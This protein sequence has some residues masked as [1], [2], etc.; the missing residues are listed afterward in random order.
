MGEIEGANKEQ[1]VILKEHQKQHKKY[2]SDLDS[3]HETLRQIENYNEEVMSE[4]AITRRAAYKAE[5]SIQEL[6]NNKTTQDGYV[7]TLNKQ[8]KALQEQIAIYSSQCKSQKIETE[9]AQSVI[10]ETVRELEMI[11]N[12][13]KQLMLQWKSA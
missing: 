8:V 6:E 11:S 12:E 4:I 1:S 10:D 3:L 13:K 9:E 5:Q 2:V 7:D